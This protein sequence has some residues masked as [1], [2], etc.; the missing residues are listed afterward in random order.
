MFALL[1]LQ[2]EYLPVHEGARQI[3]IVEELGAEA[4]EPAREVTAEAGVAGS[5]GWIGIRA[6]LGYEQGW[7]R[8]GNGSVEFRIDAGGAAPALTLL[9]TSAQ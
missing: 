4:A 1:A 3:Y 6:F 5:D 2:Q 7:M 8:A 9:K